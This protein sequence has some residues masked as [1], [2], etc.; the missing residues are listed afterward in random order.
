[1]HSAVVGVQ[2]EDLA[3]DEGFLFAFLIRDLVG[4]NYHQLADFQVLDLASNGHDLADGF[5]PQGRAGR[6]ALD[7]FGAG[8]EAAVSFA[9]GRS[10]DFDHHVCVVDQDA[11]EVGMNQRE[12]AP[13]LDQRKRP[14]LHDS[15]PLWNWGCIS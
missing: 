8:N 3:L 15:V 2:F 4:H 5:V 14:F 7:P 11:F 6:V 1:M 10:N 13:G 12:G 9:D